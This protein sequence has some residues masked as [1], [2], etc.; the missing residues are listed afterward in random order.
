[1]D[2]I[3]TRIRSQEEKEDIIGGFETF[4]RFVRLV[5]GGASLGYVRVEEVEKN[6]RRRRELVM[7]AV[8]KLAWTELG[9]WSARIGRCCPQQAGERQRIPLTFVGQLDLLRAKIGNGIAVGLRG[10]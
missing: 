8:G 6:K 1:M 10:Y 9:A 2:R 5:P 4:Q 7:G 3:E